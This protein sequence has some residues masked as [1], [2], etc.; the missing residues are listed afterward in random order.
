MEYLSEGPREVDEDQGLSLVKVLHNL[1]AYL[2]ERGLVPD[3][4]PCLLDLARMIAEPDTIPRF[5]RPE[6]LGGE[7]AVWLP[8]FGDDEHDEPLTYNEWWMALVLEKKFKRHWDRVRRA[9][10]KKPDAAA[11]LALLDRLER[12]LAED[13]EYLDDLGYERPP[14]QADYRRAERWFERENV[15]EARAW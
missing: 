13:P 2:A 14:S 10:T 3:N 4:L 12:R 6:P 5:A 9:A 1:F 15:R 7:I 11:K 8:Y